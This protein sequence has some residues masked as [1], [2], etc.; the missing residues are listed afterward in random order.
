MNIQF[1][2]HQ[3]SL[4]LLGSLVTLLLIFPGLYFP[5]PEMELWGMRFKF[6][7]IPIA[8]GVTVLPLWCFIQ[9]ATQDEER[10]IRFWIALLISVANML[11]VLRT[12]HFSI[13]GG[14]M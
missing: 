8:I 11:L 2:K 1:K 9:I 7:W 14:V 12:L 3:G 13:P 10:N 6:Y 4:A 5:G